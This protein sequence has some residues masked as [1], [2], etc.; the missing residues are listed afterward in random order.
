M[1][2][3]G[4]TSIQMALARALREVMS[5]GIWMTVETGITSEMVMQ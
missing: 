2:E 3:V 1:M 4:T 5:D